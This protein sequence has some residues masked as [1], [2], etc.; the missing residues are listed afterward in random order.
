MDTADKFWM[1]KNVK[2]GA[3]NKCHFT[4]KEAHD[5]AKRLALNPSNGGDTFVVLEAVSA[6]KRKPLEVEKIRVEHLPQRAD[7]T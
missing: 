6:Y 7:A 4:E 5:E 1:V 2:G 3:P